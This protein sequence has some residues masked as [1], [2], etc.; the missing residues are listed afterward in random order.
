MTDSPLTLAAVA[1]EFRTLGLA[2]RSAPGVYQLSYR[3]APDAPFYQT[4]DLADALETGRGMADLAPPAPPP[5]LGP[6]GRRQTRRGQM[7]NHNRRIAERRR[8]AALRAGRRE[9]KPC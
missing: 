6:V 9:G 7:I 4:D 5:P 1:D 8:M 3:T 2:I